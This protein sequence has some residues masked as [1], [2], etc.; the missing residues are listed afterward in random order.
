MTYTRWVD[1]IPVTIFDVVK[2]E[3]VDADYLRLGLIR[4]PSNVRHVIPLHFFQSFIFT[5]FYTTTLA[6]IRPVLRCP[7]SLL[8][9]S[10]SNCSL[11][12]RDRLHAAR[13]FHLHLRRRP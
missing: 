6:R 3:Q 1:Y 4:E 5:Y 7:P 13:P 11:R 9:L 12:C 10:N 8:S 2:E